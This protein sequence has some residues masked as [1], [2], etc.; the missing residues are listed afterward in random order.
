M[1]GNFVSYNYLK[2]LAIFQCPFLDDGL[3]F[4][5]IPAFRKT[6]Y[7]A[8]VR[9]DLISAFQPLSMEQVI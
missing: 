4:L 2:T 5:I 8:F 3:G 1:N 9:K 7:S 6:V